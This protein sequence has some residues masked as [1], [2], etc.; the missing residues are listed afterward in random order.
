MRQQ[1]GFFYWVKIII[2]LAI[3]GAGFFCTPKLRA[4][5]AG[6]N[7]IINEIMVGQKGAA[8]NEYI[9]LYNPTSSSISMSG[10][11]LSRKT[12]G[13]NE[14]N[15]L[16]SFANNSII[17]PYSYY[18]IVHSTGYTGELFFDAKYSTAQAI[19]NDNTII[20]Y[21]DAGKT[22]VDQAGYGTA[23]DN[24][25]SL[26]RKDD[27]SWQTSQNIGGTPQA[28]N[29]VNTTPLNPPLL[30]GTEAGAG[31]PPN[32]PL[33]G[34]QD[35]TASTTE[36]NTTPLNSPSSEGTDKP[37]QKI[38]FGDVLINEL[39]SDPAD[40]EVEWI[41]LYNKTGREIDLTGWR[42]ED[43]SQAKTNLSGGCDKYKVID[44]PN[45]SLNNAGDLVILYDASGRIIDQLA[46]GGWADG[47]TTDNAPAAGD[48]GSLARKYDGYNTYNNLNDFAVTLKLTQGS[49]NVIEIEDE[50]SPAAKA[51][52]D[53]SGD[54]YL[55]EIL[56][57]PDGDDTKLEFIE[58]YNA[59]NREV[60]LTGWSLSNEDNKKVSLEKI[61]ASAIIKAGE[62]L[63]VY[64]PKTKI[65]LHNDKGAV[66]LFQ[67]LADKPFMAVEYKNV[68]E[69]L[70]Y[71]SV[72]YKRGEW[73]WS[74]TITPAAINVFKIINHPPEAEF[75]FKLPVLINVPI[76]FDSSDT[77]DQDDDKLK[78]SWDF[79]DGF[80]NNL[81][82]PEHTYLKIGIY[83][84]RLEVNDSQATSTKEKSV[85][86]VSSVS[87]I[88]DVREIASLPEAPRNDKI[89]I[90]EIFP[91]PAG[92]DTGQ[93]WLEFK[94][95]S[96][97][98]IDL[99][100]WRV[101]NSNG[102]YEF[103][104]QQLLAAGVF[105]ILNNT[106][107]KLAFK[108]S[109]DTISLYNNLDELIDQ[110]EYANAAQ[111]ETYARGA[112]G[113]WFW[114]TKATP[115]EE[116][117]ISLA[118]SAY[119]KTAANKVPVGSVENYEE[120]DL[121]KVRA[122]EIGSQVKV[123]GT[124]AVE[125]GT[126]GVQIFYIV[127]SPG[128]Q[129]YNY[130]KD[131][132]SLKIGDYIEVAGELAQAQGEFRIKTKNKSSINF[133]EHRALPVALA[134]KAD[135]VN[136]ENIGQLIAIAGEITDKKSASL[137]V[138]DG[139]D[140]MFIYI[141]QNTGISTKNLATGQKISIA[142]ILSKTQTGLRLLPRSQ[143]DIVL[144]GSTEELAPQVLGEVA[145]AREWDLAERDKKLELFKYLIIL[146][147]GAII[148]LG[149]LLVRAGSKI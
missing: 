132:P 2:I 32:P 78:F 118:E 95:K 26:E 40:N 10:W 140:E 110:V 85:K 69:G 61:A 29:S 103:K 64:R 9:E 147:G 36:E 77:L 42:I 67:P 21:S 18:L 113:N 131:F 27:G 11:R 97:D 52:F 16:T 74:E 117:I 145:V 58:I 98:K 7:V 60:N 44:K 43:G 35:G 119:V 6:D 50:I 53:F 86:V 104:S 138:D 143:A 121:E 19:A 112:N 102:K 73:I 66:K 107:S 142:G 135:E 24:G 3:I 122:L 111:G 76:A 17:Q 99:L 108:N 79:G 130:K 22:I 56:P 81:P 41:E 30:G 88:I 144:I 128:I 23:P 25:R 109:T 20:L 139:N 37:V 51:G 63:A 136:E 4:V 148:I 72:D 33:E 126:L 13:G 115:G 149:I 65:V 80:K 124:V 31:N 106:Q 68:K 46:Y 49:N 54:I 38:N 89:V 146:A 137:Y 75:S 90:N 129:I 5:L 87:E 55:S 96:S 82:N 125:P 12:S 114:T 59:G 62:Y 1:G 91:D 28:A 133:I 47:D 105:Y 93:E 48:P 141:K 116:N 45:G 57:N 71:N 84:V 39:V 94:N 123:K 14:Y 100:N 134:I 92:A 120:T 15:L 8:N 83:K 101:E 127:G 70:S 34:R